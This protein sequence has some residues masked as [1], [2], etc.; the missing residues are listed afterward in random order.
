MW[1]V[2]RVALIV[3]LGPI[4]QQFLGQQLAHGNLLVAE[5]LQKVV[6][7][8]FKMQPGPDHHVGVPDRLDVLRRWLISVGVAT[9]PDHGGDLGVGRDVGHR[10][11]QIAGRRI[12]CQGAILAMRVCRHC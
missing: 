2:Q 12:Y 11:G 3:S 8:G 10:V 6:H 7:P 9:R 5:A 1:I 4:E